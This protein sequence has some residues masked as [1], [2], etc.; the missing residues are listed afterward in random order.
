[1]NNSLE[2]PR[3]LF[4]PGKPYAPEFRAFEGIPGIERSMNGRLWVTWYAGDIH[5]PWEGPGNFVALATSGDEGSTWSPPVL[6]IHPEGLLRAFDPCL[7][8][9]PFGKLWLFWAQSCGF[10]DGRCGVWAMTASTPEEADAGWSAPVRIC[11]GIMMNKPTVLRDGTW[12]LPVSIWSREAQE[13]TPMEHRHNLLD[14]TGAWVVTSPDAG[15]TW[16]WRGRAIAQ[17]RIFDEHMVVERGDGSLWMLIRVK[18]GIAES[19]SQDQGKTWSTPVPSPI[20]H[21][22]S[23]FYIRRLLSGRLLMVAHDPPMRIDLSAFTPEVRSRLTA[24]LSEDDGATWVGGLLLDERTG[25][26][27]PDGTQ[28]DDGRIF[29]VHDRNRTTD[30]EVLFSIFTEEDVLAGTP[31][32]KNSALRIPANKG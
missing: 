20:R 12:L 22:N 7:W 13:D 1:M 26:S 8:M 4:H 28:A 3:V 25:V 31:M 2:S 16:Q 30:R 9:D 15:R 10:F 32:S 6:V 14:K 19:V 23:R 27:Y 29:L 17:N 24:R 5:Q 11:D 18:S 21:A